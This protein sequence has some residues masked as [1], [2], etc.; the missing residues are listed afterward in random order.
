M[1]LL[2]VGGLAACPSGPRLPSA[3]AGYSRLAGVAL[4][5]GDYRAQVEIGDIATA[6][7][8]SLIDPAKSQTMMTA[9]TDASGAF[10]FQSGFVPGADPYILEAVKGLSGHRPGNPAVRVRT[11]IQYRGGWTSTTGDVVIINR[12]TTAA[13][14]IAGLRGLDARNFLGKVIAGPPSI[15]DPTGTGTTSDD[16]EQVLA[17]LGEALK[18][19]RDPLDAIQWSVARGFNLKEGAS[20]TSAKVSIID[21]YPL[22]ACTGG[23]MTIAGTNIAEAGPDNLVKFFREATAD[24][25]S[26]GPNSVTVRVPDGAQTGL[27]TLDNAL[28]KATANLTVLRAVSGV[29]GTAGGSGACPDVRDERQSPFVGRFVPSD[30]YAPG[31]F[32]PALIPGPAPTGPIAAL[33]GA[34]DPKGAGSP[35]AEAPPTLSGEFNPHPARLRSEIPGFSGAFDPLGGNAPGGKAPPPLGGEFHPDPTPAP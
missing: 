12:A 28:G 5:P 9:L 23:K 8:V 33:S 11:F 15:F 26:V 24:V 6:A 29:F 2:L 3:W 1:G 32:D 30:D 4:F 7:T 13:A 10:I 19:N 35:A 21:I 18:A 27:L 16:Y 14:I 31:Y 25:V 17:L 22:P 20:S 34:F